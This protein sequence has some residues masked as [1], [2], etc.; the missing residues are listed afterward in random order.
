MYIF[1][2]PNMSSQSITDKDLLSELPF[3]NSSIKKTMIKL[4]TDKKSLSELHFIK[5]SIL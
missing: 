4:L 1:K 3:Y 2:L 5:N